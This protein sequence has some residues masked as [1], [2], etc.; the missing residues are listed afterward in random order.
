VISATDLHGRILGFL[1][2]KQTGSGTNIKQMKTNKQNIPK[3]NWQ[4]F[5]NYDWH[6]RS[7]SRGSLVGW[8]TMLEAGRPWVKTPDE[9]TGFF[10]LP[11]PSN[12]TVGGR[13]S[14]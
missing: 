11:N 5:L 1:D 13:L 7:G 2:R 4:Y 9:V 8:G 3:D 14:L 6:S 12:R 10:I